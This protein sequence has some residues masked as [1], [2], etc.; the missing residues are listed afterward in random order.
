MLRPSTAERLRGP[1]SEDCLILS[2]QHASPV[3]PGRRARA[4]HLRRLLIIRD[5]ALGLHRFNELLESL[6][7]AA[8]S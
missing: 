7:V 1:P 8:T 5:I 3:A 6:G 4:R 2:L